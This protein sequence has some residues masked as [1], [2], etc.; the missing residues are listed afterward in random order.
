MKPKSLIP[1]IYNI[2]EVIEEDKNHRIRL[3]SDY[4]VGTFTIPMPD[5]DCSDFYIIEQTF[6]VK[7][8]A[9]CIDGASC[10]P[11][12]F[13]IDMACGYI[14]HDVWYLHLEEMAAHPDFQALGYTYDKLRKIGD[15]VFGIKLLQEASKESTQ[16]KRSG[17]TFVSR[18]YYNAVRWFGDIF[19]KLG[20]LFC[21]AFAVSL[22]TGCTGC[23]MPDETIF[24]PADEEPQYEVILHDQQEQE[25]NS[26]NHCTN[27]FL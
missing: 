26:Q 13:I 6:I 1:I 15:D 14:P 22:L 23:A 25:H 24:I 2:K 10:A 8:E 16:F 21:I 27:I 3:K 20:K 9:S 12:K 17:A 7:K 11:D 18:I 4:T 5:F 19:H